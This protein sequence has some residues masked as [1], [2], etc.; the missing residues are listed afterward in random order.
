MCR[1]LNASQ[2]KLEK[3][4]ISVLQSVFCV[5][6]KVFTWQAGTLHGGKDS[7][8]VFKTDKKGCFV[9]LPGRYISW[10]EEIWEDVQGSYFPLILK[11]KLGVRKHDIK[12]SG[13]FLEMLHLHLV[14]K[15]R[16]L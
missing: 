8:D 9:C 7:E 3:L 4:G 16:S 15:W 10:R 14:T 6:V 1:F 11:E 5:P 12:V 2:M 13:S